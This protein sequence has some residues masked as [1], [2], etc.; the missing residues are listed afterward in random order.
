MP[1]TNLDALVRI[2]ILCGF[3]VFYLSASLNQRL[4]LYVHPRMAVYI[5]LCSMVMLVLAGTACK[6]IFSQK[7]LLNPRRYIFFLIAL[8]AAWLVPPQSLAGSSGIRSEYQESSSSIIQSEAEPAPVSP[9]PSPDS[10]TDAAYVDESTHALSLLMSLDPIVMEG[11]SYVDIMM[12]LNQNPSVHKGKKIKTTGFIQRFPE[13]DEQSFVPARMMMSCCAADTI[14]I[15]LM[16]H[17]DKSS[18]LE[19]STWVHIEGTLSEGTYMGETIPVI[20]VTAATPA[21][22]IDEFIYP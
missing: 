5:A 22:P 3:G 2:F 10:A 6:S 12:E 15:G 7:Q 11:E 9:T 13:F 8:C 21:D 20:E 14:P 1:K 18:S 16:C 17:W 19:D 4:S